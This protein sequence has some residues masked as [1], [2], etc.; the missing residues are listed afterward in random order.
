MLKSY[1]RLP[2]MDLVVSQEKRQRFYSRLRLT[3]S[4]CLE[5]TGYRMKDKNGQHRY[6]SWTVSYQVWLTHRLA[7]YMKHGPIP[8]NK[9]VCHRCDN[10]ACCNVDHLF[11][12]TQIDNMVDA[13]C[14]NRQAKGALLPQTRHS[15]ETIRAIKL[16]RQNEGL[17]VGQLSQRFGIAHGHISMI[18]SGKIRKNV[19]I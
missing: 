17:K 9:E 7:W 10:P 14:K 6:G 8:D 11:L 19:T 1:K 5:W 13:I 18:L 4:G 16:A 3:E 2:T 12:G 15:D